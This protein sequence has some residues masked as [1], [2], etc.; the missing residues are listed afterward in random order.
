[1]HVSDIANG[2]E[3]KIHASVSG[4]GIVLM[5]EAIFGVSAGLLVKP[6]EYFGRYMRFLEPANVQIRNKRDGRVYKFVSTTVTPVRTR[7]GN[8]HLIRCLSELEPE[9]SR[10]A[11][12]FFID[13]LGIMSI[14]GNN[15]DLKN[16]IVHDISMRGISLVLEKGTEC[17]LGDKIDVMFRYGSSLHNY[18][19]STT[20][21]RNF[22]V[23]KKNA[24]G[25]SISDIN[26]DL[27]GFLTSMKNEKQPNLDEIPE[28]NLNPKIS[29]KQQIIEV[30]EDI[31]KELVPERRE[32]ITIT[33]RNPYDPDS[34]EHISRSE[35]QGKTLRQKKKEMRE[36]EQ[37]R[38]IENL[39]DLRNI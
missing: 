10:R 22:T 36:S 25:C 24:I 29:Q 13:G 37:A 33:S 2:S 32:T 19:L 8:F 26:V 18:E 9:N 7:Y 15:M 38:E 34:L 31:A 30:E 14:N 3:V 28:T 16:C 35:T 4:H 27:I 11:Q 6:M 21:V 17:N 12:R 1:M 39:L 5:T 20:V 23:G